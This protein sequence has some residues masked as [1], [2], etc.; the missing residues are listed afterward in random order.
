MN[1][2]LVDTSVWVDF[3][4]GHPS[5]DSLVEL[6]DT[7]QVVTNDLILA[8]LL[9]AIN[10]RKEHKLRD[11]LLAVTKVRL[12]IAWQE[13]IDMQTKNLGAG[14]NHIGIPDLVIAQNAIDHGLVLIENDKHFLPLRDQFGLRL[15]RD[16]N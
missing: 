15:Y 12:E 9:P 5:G 6:I 13:I 11:L 3:F 7:N 16:R 1:G 14:H 2:I 8:E 4:R 10:A